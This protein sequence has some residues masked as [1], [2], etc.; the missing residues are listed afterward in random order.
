LRSHISHVWPAL[1][2]PE[3]RGGLT[4]VDVMRHPEG[5][6]RDRAIHDWCR[7]VWTAFSA[8]RAVVAGLL[9]QHGII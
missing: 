2:I 7:S 9:T 5:A 8:N 1:A 6:E 4:A 3:D